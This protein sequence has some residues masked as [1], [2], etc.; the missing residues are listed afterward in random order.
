M[1]D[2]GSESS[3]DS[4]GVRPHDDPEDVGRRAHPRPGSN[5]LPA[6]P[7]KKKEDMPMRI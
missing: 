3:A 2:L 7:G 1:G 4:A 5:V 6:E